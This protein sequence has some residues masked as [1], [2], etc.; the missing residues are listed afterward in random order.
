MSIGQILILTLY[1]VGM[2]GGQ[3]L[4][5]MA[6]NRGVADGGGMMALLFNPFFIAAVAIYGAMTVVWVYVLTSLRL[7]QAYPFAILSFVLT[8]LLA[9]VIFGEPMTGRYMVGAG[10]ILAGLAVLTT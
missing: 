2:S 8:P 7:N 6:A 10:L 3:I 1:A 5:K 9:L 4:F